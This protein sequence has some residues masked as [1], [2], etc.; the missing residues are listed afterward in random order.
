MKTRA[1]GG[2][3]PEHADHLRQFKLPDALLDAAGVHS[4]S[5]SE[6]REA[7]GLNAHHGDDLSGIS[8]PYF[9]P[10]T[11]ERTGARIRLD[12]PLSGGGKYVSEPGCR[13]L[14]FP[15]GAEDL[16]PD[17][18]APVVV[19]EAEK[20]GL[21]LTDFCARAARKMLAVAIGGCWG[22]RRKIGNRAL[23][24]GGSEPETGASPDFNLV[25]WQ[26]RSVILAFDSNSST[27]RDV[28]RA[29]RELAKELSQRG[30]NV[31]LAEVPAFKGVNGPDD[32][33]ALFGDNE[34]LRVLE[35]AHEATITLRRGALP[36]AVDEAEKVLLV[37]SRRLGIFQRAGELV[38]VISLPEPT[39]G[40]GLKRLNAQLEPLTRVV[41]TETL[42][43]VVG[44][45]KFTGEN[46]TQMVDCP[47][48]IAAYYL[49][50]RGAWRVPVL[51]GI[52]SAPILR[53]DG[54]ILARPGY[55]DCTGL[56]FFSDEE[57]PEIPERLTRFD[58]ENAV[59][60][61]CHPFSEFPFSG[62][63]H[64]SVHIACILTAIQRRLLGPCPIFGYSAPTQRYGKS[65]L[66]ESVATIAT[67]TPAPATA[68]SREREEMRKAITSALRE[69]HAII[70]LDNIEHPFA[71]PDLAKAITQSIYQDRVLGESRMLQLPTNV[72]WTATGN[73]LTFRGDLPSRALMSRIDSGVERPEERTF[74]IP[75]LRNYVEINRQVI[76]GAALTIL[77]AYHVAGRPRQDVRPWGG[78]EDWSQAIREPLVWAGLPDPCIT[79]ET[80]LEDDPEREEAAGVLVAIRNAFG[81]SEF[82]VKELISSTNSDSELMNVM[83]TVAA[84]RGAKNQLDSKVVGWFCRKYRDRVMNGFRLR[85][86]GNPSSKVV[87]HW[88]VEVQNGASGDHRGHGGHRGQVPA[89]RTESQIPTNDHDAKSHSGQPESGPMT[90]VTPD[91]EVAV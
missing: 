28:Q 17:V 8:F 61:L 79:R 89:T 90:P 18:S 68:V 49:S 11:G 74:S 47:E 26:G 84:S 77:R 69:G 71:S 80:V 6:A 70:N 25:A 91:D 29:R 73:N 37:H 85:R 33:L 5:D 22:W 24:N 30:A 14:Y 21:A 1:I 64:L 13:H 32:L 50:R 58:I 67:G 56:F 34:M 4:V 60:T 12:R 53:H 20:S 3:R 51:T 52:I 76:V 78:F 81:D 57:W 9:S 88:Q 2:L 27:S 40:G 59:E 38:R 63:E 15:P 23:S 65:L 45:Q 82:T 35:C 16:L 44:W 31:T 41:L 83:L 46:S 19:V 54:T 42:D 39:K 62:K 66:A 36:A 87:A 75:D 43:R 72:L 55:D 7:F 10:V 48:K 86:S